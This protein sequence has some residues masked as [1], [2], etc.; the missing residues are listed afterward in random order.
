[1]TCFIH[2]LK[3]CIACDDV[4]VVLRNFSPWHFIPL[5]GLQQSIL[6]APLSSSSDRLWYSDLANVSGLIHSNETCQC[7]SGRARYVSVPVSLWGRKWRSEPNR[8]GSLAGNVMAGAAFSLLT[9]PWDSAHFAPRSSFHVG[10]IRQ[11]LGRFW[12]GH[13]S[14]QSKPDAL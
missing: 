2:A 13:K 11:H 9:V 1:M 3:R 7:T 10:L 12:R 4:S 5:T 8:R 14:G 6:K